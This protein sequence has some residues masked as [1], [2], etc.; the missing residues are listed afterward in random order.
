MTAYDRLAT[1]VREQI[2]AGKLR[3]GDRLP[4]EAEISTSYQV[5]RNTAREALRVLASQGLVTIRRGGTGGVFVTL[6]SPAQIAE[7]VQ[8]GVGLMAENHRISPQ[9]L[10][11]F[12]EMLEVPAAELAAVHRTE[13]E[14]AAIHATL[15][16]PTEVD[17]V[18]LYTSSRDF[19]FRVLAA[20]HNP[21][22]EIFAEPIFRVL[23]ERFLGKQVP[24]HVSHR[25][26][27][28]HRE[29]LYHLRTQNRAGAR[30][31]TRAHLRCLHLM[32]REQMP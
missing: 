24:E 5:S 14:L 26:D 3:E 27:R 17:V 32:Q 22:L 16:D 18:D 19:H 31:A 9:A 29:I 8:V 6:P 25:I 2:L 7:S 15:F 1:M 20:T 13:T 12:R 23:N 10:S 4:T 11:Q 30:E 21:L 28:E